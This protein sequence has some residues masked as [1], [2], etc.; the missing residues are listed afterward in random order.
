MKEWLQQ[1][2]T[3]Q[4]Y[5]E[6]FLNM[7]LTMHYIHNRGYGILSK[8]SKDGYPFFDVN[9]ISVVTGE[10]QS[11]VF[12]DV[13]EVS[14]NYQNQL[15]RENIYS[16]SYLAVKA[17]SNF[18]EQLSHSFLKENFNEFESFL[19]VEDIPYYKNVIR[20]GAS[21]YYSEYVQ[22]RTEREIQQ[23]ADMMPIPSRSTQLTK[24]TD[25]GKQIVNQYGQLDN[26]NNNMAAFVRLYVFP[27]IIIFLSLII[28]II[29]WIFALLGNR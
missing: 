14:P 12:H 1:P 23:A 10:R 8:R 27:A 4:E 3:Q 6:L 17:Y 28:P 15:V 19:P 29:G 13:D 26:N 7:D 5:Q 11:V 21:V 24:S 9:R 25:V 18:T 22:K 20:S 16:L 2:H